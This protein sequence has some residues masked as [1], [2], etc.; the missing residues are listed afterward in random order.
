MFGLIRNAPGEMILTGQG[1][2][3]VLGVGHPSQERFAQTL[4]WGAGG[5]RGNYEATGEKVTCL[6]A[7]SMLQKAMDAAQNGQGHWH[8]E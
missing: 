5:R 6:A 8:A 4:S 3:F 2:H 1:K 7:P